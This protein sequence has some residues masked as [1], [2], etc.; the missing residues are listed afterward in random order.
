[1][2]LRSLRS[3]AQTGNNLMKTFVQKAFYFAAVSG[4]EVRM[5][6]LQN[7]K[8]LAMIVP[9]WTV[10]LPDMTALPDNFSGLQVSSVFAL[11][12][13]QEH[14][15]TGMAQTPPR[16]DKDSWRDGYARVSFGTDDTPLPTVTETM[17]WL[18]RSDICAQGK[19][20]NNKK[21][22]VVASW[23][24]NL[25]WQYCDPDIGFGSGRTSIH[26][27]AVC[28]CDEAT[29][30]EL[31]RMSRNMTKM[32][33][34]LS[35]HMFY[36]KLFGP[37]VPEITGAQRFMSWLSARPNDGGKAMV[38]SSMFPGE[39]HSHCVFEYDSQGQTEMPEE[40]QDDTEEETPAPNVPAPAPPTG[41]NA[42][43][44]FE[45]LEQNAEGGYDFH[46]ALSAI[47]QS[48]IHLPHLNPAV[49]TDGMKLFVECLRTNRPLNNVGGFI[50]NPICEIRHNQE[51]H[52]KDIAKEIARTGA[53]EV[54]LVLTYLQP[55]QRDAQLDLAS[56]NLFAEQIS[57][58][59]SIQVKLAK[60][61][62]VM[63]VKMLATSH[64]PVRSVLW[65]RL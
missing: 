22:P 10:S 49:P 48:S 62:I 43:P 46:R 64:H 41:S 30:V 36:C 6:S 32:R 29:S 55:T 38:L 40:N 7:G 65:T 13:T 61:G 14:L 44:G 27:E 47:R 5:F 1:M 12:R 53:S 37:F 15:L 51:E 54:A 63:H 24:S 31:E 20:R 18:G 11:G 57:A 42:L 3:E 58:M 21:H 60:L 39:L 9:A 59:Q 4:C 56:I 52:E 8:T 16:D 19:R 17:L 2:L 35:N 25:A 23:E 34:G 33:V 50:Y 45:H 26:P 28:I